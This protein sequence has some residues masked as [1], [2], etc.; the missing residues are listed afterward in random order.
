MFVKLCD[1]QTL[2]SAWTSVKLKNSAGGI[3][4]FSVLD[5]ENKLEHHLAELQNELKER[6]WNPEPYLRVDIK[7]N[8]T[9]KRRLGLLSVKD[10]IV[11]QAIRI[12]IEPSFENLFLSNSYGYRPERGSAKAINRTLHEFNQQNNKWVAQLDLDNYFDTIHHELLFSRLKSIVSD[13]EIVRLIELSLKMGIVNKKMKWEEIKAGVPQG[14]VLS[15]LLA[16]FY[17]HSFDQFVTSKT[18]AYVRYADDFLM[19]AETKEQIDDLVAKASDFLQNRLY[20]KLNPHRICSRD[21][22]I[23]FLGLVLR[24]GYIGISEEK[25][26]KLSERIHS[27]NLFNGSF[28][29]R[30][31]N[32]LDGIKRYYA[33]VLPQELLLPLD[34][35]LENKL[36]DLVVKSVNSLTSKKQL[37]DEL[38]KIP[39]FADETELNKSKVIH[40]LLEL[41]TA[42][43]KESQKTT[44]ATNKQLIDKK[45]KEYQKK[46][47][48]GAELVISSFG[49]FIGKNKS[50]ISV[51]VNGKVR[52]TPSRALEHISIRSGGVSISADAI[53]YCTERN[54]PI[55]FFT[56]SGKHYASILSPV[57]VEHTLWEKQTDMDFKESAYLASCLV[58]GKLKNQLHLIKYYHKYHKGNESQ[59]TRQYEQS[60]TRL[61][62]LCM[63]AKSFVATDKDYR[64][65]LMS[66]EAEG[67]TLYWAYLRQLL[68]DDKVSFE[69]R[70][71]KGATD[72]FNSML[73]YG[74]AILYARTWQAI[75]GA[76]LNPSIGVLHTYQEGKPTLSFDLVE[77]FRAQAVDRVVVSLIQKGEPLAMEKNLLNEE[78]RKLLVKNIL[79]RLNRYEKYRGVETK[80]TAIIKLQAKE[81][82]DYIGGDTKAYKPYISKW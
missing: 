19:F 40:N 63:K 22:N 11:Q 17:L 78:T 82:A 62:A 6:K 24:A 74:Y 2:Y 48:E 42:K 7:K 33:R 8:E 57:S 52:K 28:S 5:F 49:T 55:D 32:A 34:K 67:A 50:G 38:K 73:N 46:E 68:M 20:L 29:K 44:S 12:L 39:F 75:L 72:L 45:K 14:A 13:N 51:K 21:E 70:K 80:F 16:N 26:Q 56:P 41:Y 76:K 54:I 36:S 47:G 79:E 9:E 23:E 66:Y 64:Q 35:I 1:I 69:T 77:L 4:G 27:I 60:T 58:Y 25:K 10:K 30:S 3:D 31:I 61:E 65:I 59:L 15:P 37:S 53:Q 71:R 43:K 18:T 81:L